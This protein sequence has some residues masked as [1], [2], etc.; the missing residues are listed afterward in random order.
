LLDPPQ[1][2][3]TQ[4]QGE[5]PIKDWCST[6]QARMKLTTKNGQSWYS[7]YDETAGRW[8]KGK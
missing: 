4:G 1:S 6:H 2:A 8:C 3:P 5:A 7:H